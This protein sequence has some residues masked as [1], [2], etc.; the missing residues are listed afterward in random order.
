MYAIHTNVLCSS[1]IP[2]RLC[3]CRDPESTRRYALFADKIKKAAVGTLALPFFRRQTRL[4]VAFVPCRAFYGRTCNAPVEPACTYSEKQRTKRK[5]TLAY[6]G[7]SSSAHSSQDPD[8]EESRASS[9][10]P[11]GQD[12][13]PEN[14]DPDDSNAAEPQNVDWREFRYCSPRMLCICRTTQTIVFRYA[15]QLLHEASSYVVLA[16]MWATGLSFCSCGR[17]SCTSAAPLVVPETH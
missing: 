9:K 3:A 13:Q 15:C 1:R 17:Q 14:L 12:D 5:Q 16:P 2:T 8:K 6:Q 11:A 4:N 10:T 7:G